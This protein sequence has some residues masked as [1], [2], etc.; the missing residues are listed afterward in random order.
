MI[1][2]DVM[3]NSP[4]LTCTLF[5]NLHKLHI[6]PHGLEGEEVGVGTP[7]GVYVKKVKKKLKRSHIPILWE[8]FR[9]HEK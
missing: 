9:N 5:Y 7:S 8:K 1:S 6:G 2:H 3:N 4:Q